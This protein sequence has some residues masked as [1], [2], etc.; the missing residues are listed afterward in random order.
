MEI[1]KR[2]KKR[3]MVEMALQTVVAVLVG[4]ILIILMEGMIYGIYMNK[5]END[6]SQ[7]TYTVNTTVAYCEKIGDDQYRMYLCTDEEK[8][9]W[10]LSIQKPSKAEIEEAGYKDIVW[11]AP[12]AFDLSVQPVH[13]AV[14]GAFIVAILGVYGYRFY[15]LNTSYKKLG[16][17]YKATGKIF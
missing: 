4:L 17:K 14:M 11:H 5:I 2:M 15:K 6:K 3:E 1:L 12:N 9:I 8:N 13:Y 10:Y 16:K 7:P